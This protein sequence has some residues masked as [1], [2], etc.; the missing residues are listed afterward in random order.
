MRAAPRVVERTSESTK[1]RVIPRVRE[2]YAYREILANLVRKGLKVKYT[3][4][5]LG[6]VWSLL[7]PLVFL[8]VFTFVSKVMGS[9]I[10]SYPVY[11]L[12]G[13]LAWNLFNVS[14]TLS[15]RS[16]VDNANLVKKVY[17]PRELLPLSAIGE[18][19]VDFVL[20]VS[21]LILFMIVTGYGFHPANLAL[22]P[23]VVFDLFTFTTGMAFL[24]AALNVRYRDVQYL[25]GLGMIVWFW[26]TPI[27]YPSHFV[28]EQAARIGSRI[29][30]FAVYL[31]NPMAD[32]IEGFHRALY[33]VVQ[34]RAGTVIL[35]DASLGWLAAVLATAAVASLL[36]AWLTWRVFFTLSGDFAE[37]L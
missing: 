8:A 36:L 29:D 4:S 6:A 13:L 3:A 25:V 15:T 21:V 12:S 37:E 10:P 11:L 35:V 7:N 34:P 1:L 19:L 16:V 24:F 23:L 20:Q 28:Q 30:L 18:V 22:L 26:L 5:V 31:L 33:G 9:N 32:I 17:F 14:V 27:V 2:L